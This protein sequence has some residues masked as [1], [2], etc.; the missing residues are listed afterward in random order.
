MSD[1]RVGLFL[2]GGVDSTL[3]LSILHSLGLA[4]G[5]VCITGDA[6][7]TDDARYAKACIDQLGIAAL[8]LPLPYDKLGF[9]Q[10]LAICRAQAKPFPMIGNVLGMH[11]LYQAVAEHNIRVVL[12]GTG[13]DEIFGG[14][15]HRYFA[16]ALR[17]A[18]AAGDGAWI[19]AAEPSMPNSYRHL[20]A[21]NGYNPI[22]EI[23]VLA[24]LAL[25]KPEARRRVMGMASRDPLFG[26]MAGSPRRSDRF[27]GRPHA[28][29]AVAERP[30][31]DGGER[32][33]P[34]SLPRLPP[35]RLARHALTRQ[36][37]RAL[38]QAGAAPALRALHAAA[39]GGAARQAGLPLGLRPL[40][41]NNLD[42]VLAMIAGAAVTRR[43]VDAGLF[44]DAVRSG[45]V[46]L[47]SHLLHRLTVLAGLEASGFATGEG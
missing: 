26:H 40:F 9:D 7:R 29:M 39:H 35:R 32:R 43:Y 2:S 27:D 5:V 45:R 47:D 25:L 34:Q 17:D 13:A 10:F 23:P 6:G 37:R 30:Q 38:E 20:H 22:R 11:A 18:R 31:R 16:A 42:A 3:I 24:D 14:Y 44:A 41:R 1:R 46:G 36:V 12:D 33:E 4:D 19:A 8:N 21:R 15:W 28:G